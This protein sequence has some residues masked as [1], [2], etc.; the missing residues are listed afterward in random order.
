MSYREFQIDNIMIQELLWKQFEF[1]REKIDKT[2]ESISVWNLDKKLDEIEFVKPRD[3]ILVIFENVFDF[4]K[5][6][7]NERAFYNFN[8]IDNYPANL[9]LVP[10]VGVE[11][12]ENILIFR[13][14]NRQ[15]SKDEI[16][17]AQEEAEH[18]LDHHFHSFEKFYNFL[19]NK[20]NISI[21]LNAFLHV[22]V[23]QDGGEENKWF[24]PIWHIGSSFSYHRLLD[25]NY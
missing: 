24:S 2:E 21:P 6:L 20:G 13:T 11:Y 22:E 7:L 3:N 17:R 12:H 15:L 18:L 8:I 9:L 19:Y 25:P 16:F 14:T 10:V 5:E 1:A 23:F 4:Q